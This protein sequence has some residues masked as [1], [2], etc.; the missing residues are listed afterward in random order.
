MTNV[1]TVA[2]PQMQRVRDLCDQ[3][4]SSS[5]GLLISFRVEKYGSLAM[6]KTS[7]RSMQT[8][9]CSLRVRSRRLAQRMSGE[10]SAMLLSNVKG[11]YDDIACVVR[12]LPREEGYT[13]AFVP[14]FALDMDLEV[15][16]IGTGKPFAGEDPRMNRFLVLMGKLFKEQA[17][18]NRQRRPPINPFNTEELKFLWEYDAEECERMGVPAMDSNK[19]HDSTDYESVDLATLDESELEIVNPGDE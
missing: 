5:D 8:T 4:K 6:C 12:P 1:S 2:T 14:A 10:S 18:A 7:A 17:E 11:D 15:T 9:F 16:D 3:A 13:V 19:V